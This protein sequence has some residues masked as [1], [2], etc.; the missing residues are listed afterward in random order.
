MNISLSPSAGHI[1]R[2]LNEHDFEAYAVGGCVR[3]RLLGQEPQDW[4]FCTLA[5]PEEIKACFP[6]ERCIL[7]GEK[8]GTVSVLFQGECFEIT[9][10]RAE[11]GY[12]DS[13][14]PD[15]VR[16]VR[17]LK[18]DLARR[19]FTVNAMAADRNGAVV[20]CFGGLADLSQGLIRCVGEPAERFSE[21]ALRMLRALRFAS[22]LDFQIQAQTAQA[23]HRQ[24]DALALV[25]PERLRSE[26]DGLLCGKAAGRVL[27]EFPD[28]L[29]ALVPE[30]APCIGFEQH[31]PHHAFSVWEHSLRALENSPATPISRLAALLHDVGKPDSFFFDKQLVGHFYGHAVSGAALCEKILR[32]L[33]YDSASVQQITELVALHS[34]P[35]APENG[36]SLRRLLG[37]L[38]EAQ[39]RRLLALRRADRLATGTEAPERIEAQMAELNRSLEE[40]LEKQLCFSLRQLRLNGKDLMALGVPQGE[41]IG[42]LLQALLAA[43]IEERV[44]NEPAELV[45]YAQILIQNGEND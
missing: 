20:D 16:F 23:I 30:L 33:R 8:Y 22:R 5:T 3:D 36:R 13:R 25:A 7:T 26:L 44:Q 38:G 43:V 14:H 42:Q 15:G 9:T 11:T 19:D 27:R 24:K 18:E 29:C 31:N 6:A 34:V 41:R 28:V 2:R 32:R 45:R 37:R 35:L 40:I 12:S 10:F 17:S 4:D 21:D 39:T 1:L